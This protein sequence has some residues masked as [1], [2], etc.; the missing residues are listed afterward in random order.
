MFDFSEISPDSFPI[1]SKLKRRSVASSDKT[2][3]KF[4]DKG[5]INGHSNGKGDA[6][7]SKK[8]PNYMDQSSS[9]AEY[10]SDDDRQNNTSRKH[11]NGSSSKEFSRKDR[12]Q[13]S[14]GLRSREAAAN[15]SPEVPSRTTRNSKS[16]VTF[17]FRFL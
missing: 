4:G 9:S 17:R 8:Q 5:N 12:P 1:G 16:Q 14:S 6:K 3:I 15:H 11:I 2:P 13:R 7:T 10:L